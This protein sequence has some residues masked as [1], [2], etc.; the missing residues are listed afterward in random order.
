M[1]LALVAT[2]VLLA[3]CVKSERKEEDAGV[4]LGAVVGTTARPSGLSTESCEQILVGAEQKLAKARADAPTDCHADGDCVLV[5]SSACVPGCTDRAMAKTAAA[6]YRAAR[7]RL[8]ASDCKR[9][10]DGACATTTPKP[11]PTCPPV[12]A[13]CTKGKCTAQR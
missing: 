6:D 8:R 10:N 12:R 13:A 7:D 1:R 11:A 3:A 5:E 9:W 2:L 4:P